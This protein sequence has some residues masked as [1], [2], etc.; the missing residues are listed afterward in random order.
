M[1]RI[2]LNFSSRVH[3]KST[4]KVRPSNDLKVMYTTYRTSDKY[5]LSSTQSFL[6]SINLSVRSE[7][8]G[9]TLW[10]YWVSRVINY[11]DHRASYMLNWFSIR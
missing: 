3:A 6:I 5:N 4:G 1:V 8:I 9:Y 11:R 2:S 10:L 7:D